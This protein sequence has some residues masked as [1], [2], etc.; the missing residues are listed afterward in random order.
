MKVRRYY[1]PNVIYF[2]TAVTYRRKTLFSNKSNLLI[3]KETFENVKSL[4]PFFLQAYVILPDHFHLLIQPSPPTN[5]SKIL[6]SL[7]RNFTLNFKK[8]KNIEDSLKLWQHRFWDHI[9]RNKK[10]YNKHFD[11]IHYNPVKHGLV[12]KPEEWQE[13]SYLY[14]LKEG[15]YQLGWG[16]TQPIN[17]KEMELE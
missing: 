2:I 13:S 7:Q 3:F 5:I 17:I 10:D 8:V 1:I 12:K 16:Y 4:H 14:Y 15:F 9:I 11:Y 6:H